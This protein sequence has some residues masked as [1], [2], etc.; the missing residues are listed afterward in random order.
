MA[1][2][3]SARGA[4]LLAGLAHGTYGSVEEMSLFAPKIRETVLPWHD[5]RSEAA[6]ALYKKLYPRLRGG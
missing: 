2:V 4:A 5:G 3:A 6:Y 1:P